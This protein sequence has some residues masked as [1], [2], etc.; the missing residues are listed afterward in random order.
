MYLAYW[1][2]Q[3]RT[4]LTM[5]NRRHEE[6]TGKQHTNSSTEQNMQ[7]GTKEMA[8]TK[9]EISLILKPVECRSSKSKRKSRCWLCSLFLHPF[10][11]S[12]KSPHSNSFI[13]AWVLMVEKSNSWIYSWNGQESRKGF[14]LWFGAILTRLLRRASSIR[15][16][17]FKVCMQPINCQGEINRNQWIF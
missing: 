15:K 13:M 2:Y 9:D 8:D 14:P 10:F 16:A 11:S 3:K 6:P 12:S 17:A 1:Q 7:S 5:S 4:I